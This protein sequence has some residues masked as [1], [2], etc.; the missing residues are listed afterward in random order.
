M[1][2]ERWPLSLRFAFSAVRLAGVPCR[3]SS[4]KLDEDLDLYSPPPPD[5]WP[6]MGIIC[7]TPTCSISALSWL[8][9]VCPFLPAFP[10]LGADRVAL[11]VAS[12]PLPV[13][14]SAPSAPP[15]PGGAGALFFFGTPGNALHLSYVPRALAIMSLFSKLP[16]LY[17]SRELMA[18]YNT[19]WTIG[20]LYR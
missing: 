7:S 11:T 19:G 9:K 8:V 20:L 6:V 12:I 1:V 5:D 17:L 4:S 16:A 18:L 13:E 15:F 14:V 2:T 10:V 3:S